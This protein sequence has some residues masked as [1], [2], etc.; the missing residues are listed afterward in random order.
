MPTAL[1]CRTFQIPCTAT[2]A[3]TFYIQD[4]VS[5]TIISKYQI[6]EQDLI[7]QKRYFKVILGLVI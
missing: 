1:L 5:K 6:Q 3:S 4:K 2:E 7:V